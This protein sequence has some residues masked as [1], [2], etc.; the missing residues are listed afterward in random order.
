MSNDASCTIIGIETIKITIFDGVVRALREVRH[1]LDVKE[2]D[3]SRNTKLKT[4]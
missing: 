2:F 1:V 3:F 4:L